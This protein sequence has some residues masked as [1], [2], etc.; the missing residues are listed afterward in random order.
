MEKQRILV[1]DDEQ[2]LCDIL[3]FNLRAAGYEASAAGSADE[4]LQKIEDSISSNGTSFDLLLLDVMM[5]GMS[6]FQLASRLRHDEPTARL[7]I[8]F[9]TARD[10][11]DDL[12]RGF[13]LGA[14]DYVAKPFS[15]R[16][17]MARVAA[18][19]SRSQPQRGGADTLACQGLVMN[20]TQK[21]VAVDRADVPLTKTE[22]ELLRL[23]LGRRGEVL[24]RQ[25]L[26]DGAWP[27]DVVVTDRTVD[28]TIARLR[29]KLGPYAACIVAR[30]GFGYC[31]ALNNK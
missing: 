8:I 22:F 4:A 20:L 31:F 21:T 5:P 27:H 10:T 29:K 19:L 7:P 1:V 28:V 16:E 17:V 18:V 2:D 9:L 13:S 14:D 12:L 11:E 24:S 30:Q 6:G 25:Q 3:L 26:L 23:L 15:V